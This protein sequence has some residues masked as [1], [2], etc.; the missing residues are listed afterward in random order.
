MWTNENTAHLECLYGVWVP[1][2][3]S[4]FLIV[5]ET[6]TDQKLLEVYLTE[7]PEYPI[8]IK[9]IHIVRASHNAPLP[10]C[11][12]IPIGHPLFTSSIPLPFSAAVNHPVPDLH[13]LFFGYLEDNQIDFEFIQRLT[14]NHWSQDYC[15]SIVVQSPISIPSIPSTVAT[16]DSPESQHPGENQSLMTET[17]VTQPL[18]PSS[19]S[20]SGQSHWQSTTAVETTPFLSGETSEHTST[21]YTALETL[22]VRPPRLPTS[23]HPRNPSPPS[24]SLLSMMLLNAS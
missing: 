17:R 23:P 14:Q 22:L 6:S 24:D 13:C 20:S 21:Y 5:K 19:P 1:D 10:T 4:S 16:L 9:D 12:Q 7:D 3:I 2:F 15:Q 11:V 18:V 8:K